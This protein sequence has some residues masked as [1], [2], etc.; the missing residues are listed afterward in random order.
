MA[1]SCHIDIGAKNSVRPPRNDMGRARGNLARASWTQVGLDSG[2]FTDGLHGPLTRASNLSAS[3]TNHD[4]FD[5][6]WFE[7]TVSLA[8]PPALRHN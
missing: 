6:K 2:R 4:S 7:V 5:I 3:G 8:R 1:A